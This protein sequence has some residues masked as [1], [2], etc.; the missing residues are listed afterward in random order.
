MTVLTEGDL[1]IRLPDGAVVRKFDDGKSH[2]LTHC[3]KAVDFVV[4]LEDRILFIEFKDP[5]NPSARADEKKKFLQQLQSG[6]LD[7]D[8]KIKYRDSFLYEWASGRATK[9]IDYLVLIGASVLTEADLLARTDA[10]KRQVPVLGPGDKPWKKPF[11]SGCAVMNV[12]TWN[13]ALPRFP[14]TR[15]SARTFGISVTGAGTFG[16]RHPAG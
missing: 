4:E 6:N 11:I 2:G 15:L 1:Q 3:M 12:E 9:P 8:L 14:V 5:E 7:A 13:R 10:L 16:G